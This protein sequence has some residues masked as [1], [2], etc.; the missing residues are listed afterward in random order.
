MAD[1]ALYFVFEP[2]AVANPRE[3]ADTLKSD[4]ERLD[5]IQTAQAST[6]ETVRFTGL[7]ILAAITLAAEVIHHA[8]DISDNVAAIAANVKKVIETIKGIAKDLKA[9]DVAIPVNGKRRSI[10]E[11]KDNDYSIIAEDLSEDQ[12]A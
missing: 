8:K 1:L 10:F 11:L 6:A 3:L 5:D 12:S 2:N 4:L 9:K 7:E